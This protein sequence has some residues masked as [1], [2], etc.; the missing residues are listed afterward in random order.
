MR[1][2]YYWVP[3]CPFCGSE[4]TGRFIFPMPFQKYQQLVDSCRNGE[5]VMFYDDLQ[6]ETAF[7]AEC[8][9][10]WNAKI[11]SR[12]LTDAERDAERKKRDVDILYKEDIV[13]EA[14][15]QENFL[16]KKRFWRR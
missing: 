6:D 5:L 13:K 14:E 11:E 1:K 4:K 12:F 3:P 7:C 8:G 10:K 16:S 2:T 15:D 9:Y